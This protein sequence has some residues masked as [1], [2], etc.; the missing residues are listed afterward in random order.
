MWRIGRMASNETI[1]TQPPFDTDPSPH[2]QWKHF[3]FDHCD[4]LLHADSLQILQLP[5][6]HWSRLQ[7]APTLRKEALAKLSARFTP[8]NPPPPLR[9]R[10]TT[11]ALNVAERCNLRCQY[12]YA[13]KGDY[14]K[15]SM[16]HE[17]I[18]IRSLEYFARKVE[19]LHIR[20]FGGEPL[21]NFT[22]I[23]KVV[24][25]CESS[26][27]RFTFAVT[28]NGT[29]L[30][31]KHLDF[32]R[33]YGFHLNVS[34]DGKNLQ[35]KQRPGIGG[36]KIASRVHTKIQQ[37]EKSLSSLRQF[38]LRSTLTK[39][40]LGLLQQELLETL[41]SHQY[42]FY[43]ARVSSADSEHRL[44][45]KGPRKTRTHSS[46]SGGTLSRK[47]RLCDSAEFGKHAA[48]GTSVASR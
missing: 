41:N 17:Q 45:A 5:S 42:R 12:C 47:K 18:A 24:A 25:W 8:K 21:L 30:T 22:L 20:F 10:I 35:A 6:G 2:P 15:D 9:P 34:Y 28:T 14:G 39:Q 48:H 40:S 38:S 1:P 37:Y 4:Y 16:M 7:N 27:F 11:V 36:S 3:S 13:G 32:F 31:E 46:A 43:Y 33:R 26:P 19:T 44:N 29:L 23:Q